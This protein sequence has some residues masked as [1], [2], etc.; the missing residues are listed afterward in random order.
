M[1]NDEGVVPTLPPGRRVCRK[2]TGPA[3]LALALI[4][5]LPAANAR[6]GARLLVDLPGQASDSKVGKIG[7]YDLLKLWR[8][9]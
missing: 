5:V 6:G 7:T 4:G 8:V 2:P 1:K 9:S 3:G